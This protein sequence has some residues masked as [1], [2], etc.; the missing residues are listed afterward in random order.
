MPSDVSGAGIERRNPLS[1]R[2]K[3]ARQKAYQNPIKIRKGDR[4][5]VG[6][7]D[8]DWPAFLWCTDQTGESGWVPDQ[9]LQ[10]ESHEAVVLDDYSAIEL[11]VVDGETL[12][13]SGETGGW[14]WCT[15]DSGRAGWVPAENLDL[16]EEVGS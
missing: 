12:T 6:R 16:T 15:N 7:R 10:V 14:Y 3:I 2:V 9:C 5:R 4:V 1:V 11:S 8:T 13:L